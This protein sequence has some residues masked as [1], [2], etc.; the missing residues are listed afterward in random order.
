MTSLEEEAGKED[1]I[2]DPGEGGRPHG[3]CGLDNRV[4]RSSSVLAPHDGDAVDEED[5]MR[6]HANAL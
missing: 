6:G 5:H 1:P 2:R 4:S 3:G